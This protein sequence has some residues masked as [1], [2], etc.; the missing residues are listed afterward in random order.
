VCLS[1]ESVLFSK[2]SLSTS[3]RTGYFSLLIITDYSEGV[4]L[5][6][7]NKIVS[8]GETSTR[9]N[10]NMEGR[11]C[12]LTYVAGIILQMFWNLSTKDFPY[13]IVSKSKRVEAS[14]NVSVLR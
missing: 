3:Y 14:L 7:V 11:K 12:S 4:V 9:I 13:S 6:R 5:Q 2:S 10:F 1:E 8:L